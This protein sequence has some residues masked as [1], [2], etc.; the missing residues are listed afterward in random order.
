MKAVL[1]NLATLSPSPQGTWDHIWRHFWLTGVLLT[2]SASSSKMLPIQR[3]APT[4]KTKPAQMPTDSPKSLKSCV[5]VAC[6]FPLDPIPPPLCSDV[7]IVLFLNILS[8]AHGFLR[9]LYKRG[10][11]QLLNRVLM[12][13]KCV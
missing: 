10:Y 2:F 8:H 1:P 9:V 12:S 5:Q 13:L 7:T 4:P 3:T 6:E 11:R